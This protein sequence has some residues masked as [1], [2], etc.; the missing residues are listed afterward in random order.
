MEIKND[1]GTS[2]LS[3][4]DANG[5]AISVTTTV[6]RKFGSRVMTAKTGIMLN[7]AID[8]FSIP[9]RAKRAISVGHAPSPPNYRE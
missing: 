2:S 9:G 3:A 8:D 6:G 4:M 5:L 1:H 7:D